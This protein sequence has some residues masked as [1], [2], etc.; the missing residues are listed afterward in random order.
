MTIPDGGSR[1]AFEIVIFVNPDIEKC[2]ELTDEG[3]KWVA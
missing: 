2:L 3:Y 1:E